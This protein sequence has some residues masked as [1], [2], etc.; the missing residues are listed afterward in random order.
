[1]ATRVNSARP[2]D[3]LWPLETALDRAIPHL[4]WMWPAFWLAY[5]YV[6]V[7]ASWAIWRLPSSLV[8][9]AVVAFAAMT[10]IGAS[11]QMLVP[12]RS[13]WPA[14]PHPI[15]QMVHDLALNRPFASLPSMHVAFTALTAL[16]G[17]RAAR[18]RRWLQWGFALGAGLITIST[19]TLKEHFLLDPVAGAVLAG[20]VFLWWRRGTNRDA[21]VGADPPGVL[22]HHPTSG[23]TTAGMQG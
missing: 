16:F 18:G 7:G 17:V 22:A 9:R 4:G 5:P 15:Q 14:D 6:L 1:V 2:E 21:E 20:G 10:V 3:A 23:T 12:A 8:S 19:I 11:I 13:P